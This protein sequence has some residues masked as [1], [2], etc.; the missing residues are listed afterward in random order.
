MS[1]DRPNI[2][3][4]FTDMQRADTI[5]ALGNPVIR[6]PQLDRL[7][8]EGTSFTSCYTPS[9]VCVAARCSM[10]YGLYPR[11]TGQYSN[12]PMMDDNGKSLPALLGRAG[13]RTGAIG[14]CHFTPRKDELR[15]FDSRLF[16]AECTSNP[17]TDDYIRYLRDHGYDYYEPMGAR[18]EMYY[19]PQVSSLPAEAHP[20]QWIG[21]RSIDFIDEATG[22]GRPWMLFSSFIHPH[23]PLAPPKPWHKLYRGPDMPLPFVPQHSEA[24]YTHVNRVQN[25][26]KYRDQGLDNHLIRQIKA[27][28]YA[29]ISF[30]DFQLGRMLA[31]LEELGQ[32]DNTLILFASDHGELLGDYN[33]FG[34]RSMHDAAACVPMLARYPERFDPG[35]ICDD[36]C[37]L[38]DVLPT[39]IAAAGVDTT[40]VELDGIDLKTVADGPCDGR[41]VYCQHE[42]DG[43][44]IYTIITRRWKYAYSAADRKE[45]LFDRLTDRPD[46]RN[47]ANTPTTRGPRADLKRRLLAY[48]QAEGATE[49]Y[50]DTDGTLDWR[51]HPPVD[52]SFL[53][54]PDARLLFQDSP[55]YE[56]N[57]PGY[58]D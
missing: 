45:F 12:G 39:C 18:G 27:Y 1:D 32:M 26:Y 28:Y 19:I 50:T 44:A 29:T 10:H 17:E 40:G 3:L 42:R 43:E 30:V 11:K 37:S 36:V 38:V 16:Q 52:E 15:G 21:D 54:D 2:L 13:Y 25:R 51:L 47:R 7:V 34:K 8:H 33:C 20:S 46:S 24:L 58:T 23:P 55:P 5:G 6:T 9:P 41:E 4:V 48:L 49:A 31:T 56:T 14:K 35:R 57:L 53:D 22:E